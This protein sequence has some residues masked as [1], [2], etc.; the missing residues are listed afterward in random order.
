MKK[1]WNWLSF[2]AGLG[3]ALVV[4]GGVWI[5][6]IVVAAQQ[7]DEQRE[8]LACMAALGFTPDSVASTAD[9][10]GA[11]YAAEICGG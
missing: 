10:E 5:A 2:I 9:I 1:P 8:Y 6:T 3:G 7:V 4:L 11:L